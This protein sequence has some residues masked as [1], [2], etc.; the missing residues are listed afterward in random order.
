M[1]SHEA[2]A[3][4][5]TLE[6]SVALQ[7][8]DVA[9]DLGLSDEEAR[10]RLDR[11]G[12][13]ELIE[14]GAK[15]P[16]TIL[17]EQVSAIMVLILVGAGLLS[18][19]LGKWTEAGAILAIVVLFVSLGFLQEYRAERAIAALKK[20]TVPQA[21]VWRGGRIVEL[22]AHQLVPGDV[23]ALEAGNLVPADVRIVESASLRVQEAALT[24]ESEPIDKE[25]TPILA[26]DAPLGDRRNMAYRGTQVSHGRG[27][28][29]VVATG[30]RTELGRIADMIQ[31]VKPGQTPLQRKLDQVGKGL[32][33]VGAV[34]AVMV[35]V[36]GVLRGETVQDMLLTAISVAVA[37]VPE[38]LPAVVTFTLALGAQRMLARNALV[39]KLPAVETLGSVTVICSDKTGTLTENRMTVTVVDTAGDRFELPSSGALPALTATARLVLTAGVLANDAQLQQHPQESLTFIGDPT[40][41]ALLVAAARSGLDPTALV[42]ALP[43]VAELPFDS[44]RKRMTTVHRLGQPSAGSVELAGLLPTQSDGHIAFVKGSVDGLLEI[45]SH[46]WDGVARR[47]L[48]ESWRQRIDDAN[49]RLAGNGQRVLGFGWRSVSTPAADPSLE[50]DLTF[51]GLVG[52]IDPPRPE[53]RAAAAVAAQAGIRPMMITGD[54]PLTARAIARDLGITSDDVVVTGAELET[55]D[56]RQLGDAVARTSVFA[57]VAPEHKLRIVA[58]LQRQG[59][60]VAMTGDGVND[61]PALKQADIGVAMGITG[62]DVSKE[63][64][65]M[66]LRDD[67]F[68]TIVAAVEEGRTIYDNVRRFV[69]FSLAGNVAKVAVMLV[70]PAVIA[71]VSGAAADPVA[72]RPLQLL[73]LNLMTDGLLGLGLGVERAERDVMRR[74]PVA[75]SAGIFSGGMGWHVGW[76]GLWIA[77]ITLGVGLTYAAAG[78]HEWQ[79]MMF[80]TLAFAQIFQALGSR[81]I[82]DSFFTLNPLSNRLLLAMAALVAGLQILVIYLPASEAFFGVEALTGVDLAIAVGLGAA[83]L[84]VMEVE[85]A[86]LRRRA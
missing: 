77:A 31:D 50:S 55:M 60:V 61:A 64:A 79:T 53:A 66:V 39:R 63:A 70:W 29:V 32:A 10:S 36:I 20:L 52:M 5:H 80:S 37:V 19:V 71:F 42:Q 9:P 58:A 76:L 83:T 54:H 86:V 56:D 6:R 85:K 4:W 11:H 27:R 14:R 44:G 15:S 18:A 2:T 45:A 72:L 13:N 7:T 65:A 67:N 74:P 17:W 68:A 21:R 62:T 26:V 75:P 22:P 16:W 51:I 8:L 57:R 12:P 40:E 34:V 73:W 81:S 82:R 28:A 41:G 78:R 1:T 48:D 25:I 33:V 69:K 46:V 35:L 84:L 3:P 47:P 24:G 59:H 49:H 23:I 30:M 38:G 43:R